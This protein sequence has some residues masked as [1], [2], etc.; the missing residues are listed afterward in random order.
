MAE[1]LYKF[2]PAF[3]ATKV[4]EEYR[5]KVSTLG[6][7]NDIYDCVPV[8]KQSGLDKHSLPNVDPAKVNEHLQS[9]FGLLC[10]SRKY[11]S[12]LLWGHYADRATGMALGFDPMRLE[13]VNSYWRIE[14]D[15]R[16]DRP[17]LPLPEVEKMTKEEQRTFMSRLVGVKEKAWEHEEEIRFLVAL[18]FCIPS[19][20]LY[21]W[22]FEKMFLKEV[23]LGP[24]CAVS[25]HY[26]RHLV[27]RYFQG[28]GVKIITTQMHPHLFAI[29]AA[30]LEQPSGAAASQD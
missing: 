12:T 5:L 2:I 19:E 18:D 9:A 29:Q 13:D 21:F 11:T 24:K 20:G 27:E 1:V 10:F 25:I 4:L 8:V 3:F 22:K 23:I 15:Y 28:C 26:V 17:E 7:L 14:V 16:R 30:A 6:Q